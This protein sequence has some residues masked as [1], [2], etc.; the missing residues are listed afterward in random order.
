MDET[1]FRFTLL[2]VY[3]LFAFIRIHYGVRVLRSGGKVYGSFSEDAEREGKI[4]S[5]VG[6]LME[7]IIPLSAL[8]YVV[9]PSWVARLSFPLHA[10]LRLGGAALSLI[11]L[12]LLVPIHRALGRHWSASLRLREGHELVREGLYARVRHPMY[13]ALFGNVLGLSLL[14]ANWVVALPRAVQ[15]FR[16]YARIGGEEAMMLERFGEEYRDYMS[17]TGRLLPARVRGD[18]PHAP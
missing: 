5:V 12:A 6:T 16:L 1:F 15:L 18:G 2:G 14:S 4:N 11:C 3:L 13:A 7:F 9:N 8:L 17:R 10:W